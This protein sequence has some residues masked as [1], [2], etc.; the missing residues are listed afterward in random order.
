MLDML[1]KKLGIPTDK[2][3][4]DLGGC[5]KYRV[6]HDSHRTRTFAPPLAACG[7]EDR[8]ARGV[9]RG[10]FMGSNHS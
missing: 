9:R 1:R 7:R 8:H 4:V 5:R 10:L 3:I 6:Q 2:F